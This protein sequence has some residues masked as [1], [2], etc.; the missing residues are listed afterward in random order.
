MSKNLSLWTDINLT[1]AQPS[2]FAK[3]TIALL[4]LRLYYTLNLQYIAQDKVD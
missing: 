4:V 2:Q 3:K 1:K